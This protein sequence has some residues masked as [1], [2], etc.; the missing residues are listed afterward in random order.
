M[1]CFPSRALL[2]VAAA[3]LGACSDAPP[4]L[5]SASALG[6]PGACDNTHWIGVATAGTCS[7]VG[8]WA[9]TAL[10]P[11]GISGMVPCA[12]V[13]TGLG[14][15]LPADV[16]ALLGTPSLSDV[17]RDCPILAPMDVIRRASG[18]PRRQAHHQRLGLPLPVAARGARLAILDTQPHGAS[19]PRS[20]HGPLMVGF[21]RELACPSGQ[22]CGLDVR[23]ELALPIDEAG[24]VDLLRGGF[25]GRL[26]HL[27]SALDSAVA[28]WQ[29]D[30]AASATPLVLSLSLGWSPQGELAD[31][32]PIDHMQDLLTYRPGVS[33]PVRAVHA[34][35]VRA[36]C[37]GAL[38]VAAGGNDPTLRQAP[39]AL[40]PA[41]WARLAAPEEPECAV[42][43]GKHP[44]KAPREPSGPKK[45][46][47]PLEPLVFAIGGTDL[48]D[49]P[50]RVGRQKGH[51]SLVVP[52]DHAA[53]RTAQGYVV[54]S[55]TSIAAVRA[56]AAAATVWSFRP[57]LTPGE[58][59]DVLWRTGVPLGR[60]TSLCPGTAACP[61]VRRMAPCEALQE[62][63]LTVSCP[64]VPG[65]G[66][67]S[68]ASALVAQLASGSLQSDVAAVATTVPTGLPP[69]LVASP[70]CPTPL[71][72]LRPA[73][74]WLC[75]AD[76]VPAAG[77]WPHIAP[78]PE[79]PMCPDC[80]YMASSGKLLLS[81]N[82][83]VAVPAAAVLYLRSPTQTKAYDVLGFT[84]T[85]GGLLPGQVFLLEG[86]NAA[87]SVEEAWIEFAVQSGGFTTVRAD[88]ITVLP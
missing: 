61:G 25:Y 74:P 27:A 1:D 35:L 56:A 46:R 41:A 68:T 76:E 73:P 88:P 53:L 26:S 39:G 75:P 44:G 31:T 10:P 63:G 16:A 24:E 30:P 21:A 33:G 83:S 5:Q 55:G 51:G 6:P 79:D 4:T 48:E 47:A 58:L 49:H 28:G 7:S 22:S 59:M 12:Y 71:A 40:L 62:I 78:Q 65:A 82:T 37:A 36:R 15:P 69:Y 60:S 14:D 85:Y 18:Y 86:L 64:A 38:I 9:A 42:L 70:S 23:P 87:A 43:T 80:V 45:D 52:S 13:W 84:L 34:A 3:S 29:S 32:M 11:I 77:I 81:I 20:L 2:A 67:P 19:H 54:R 66:D 8:L 50:S 57:S 72:S 17:A